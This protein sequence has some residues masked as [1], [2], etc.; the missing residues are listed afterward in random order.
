M[1]D[2]P[3]SLGSRCFAQTARPTG[4][5]S[6][7]KQFWTLAAQI[8]AWHP[9]HQISILKGDTW[10]CVVFLIFV[11]DF[12]SYNSFRFTE[13]E[14]LQR[15]PI[16]CLAPHLCSLSHCRHPPPSRYLYYDWCPLTQS[17]YCPSL[18]L[19]VGLTLGAVHSMDKCIVTCICHYSTIQSNFTA[20]KILCIPLC[21]KLNQGFWPRDNI[22]QRSAN[23]FPLPEWDHLPHIPS[24]LAFNLSQHPQH[25]NPLSSPSKAQIQK[26]GPTAYCI[27]CSSFHFKPFKKGLVHRA[28]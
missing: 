8:Q 16:Y 17:H 24:P 14:N 13:S 22:I 6:L 15:V 28:C 4:C 7:S 26:P 10:A 23:R 19:T 12:I 3:L 5:S 20:L 11:L 21:K 1:Y 2:L 18:W 9:N 25:H 27:D